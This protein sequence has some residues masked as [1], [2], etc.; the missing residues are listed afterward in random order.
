MRSRGTCI[1]HHVLAWAAHLV[2]DMCS[3][4]ALCWYS[5]RVILSI[6]TRLVE[7]FIAASYWLII[8][9]ADK[10]H[11]GLAQD[12]GLCVSSLTLRV[13]DLTAVQPPSLRAV[14]ERFVSSTTSLDHTLSSTYTLVCWNTAP[15]T[16]CG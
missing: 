2:N 6:I 8:F 3:V 13:E 14:H 15:G 10:V 5:P 7:D 1:E 4:C 12:H 16:E 9:E 11:F